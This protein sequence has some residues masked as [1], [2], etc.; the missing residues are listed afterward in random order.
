MSKLK[1]PPKKDRATLW[2]IAESTA[3]A[4]NKRD[5]IMGALFRIFWTLEDDEVEWWLA[6]TLGS[7]KPDTIKRCTM[8]RVVRAGGRSVPF[9]WPENETE[10]I[11]DLANLDY[12]DYIVDFQI[13]F[14]QPLICSRRSF[15]STVRPLA[16]PI[17]LV[18]AEADTSEAARQMA[19]TMH[20]KQND[21]YSDAVDVALT[22]WK[23]GDEM[24]HV[25]MRDFLHKKPDYKS[26]KRDR[27]KSRLAQA[28]REIGKPWLIFGTKERREHL[29][30]NPQFSNTMPQAV[31]QEWIRGRAEPPRDTDR[32]PPS[33][34]QSSGNSGCG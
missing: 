1:F 11:P 17:L 9:A 26:L 27:L 8:A 18:A 4:R 21:P 2:E 19:A 16:E 13:K 25:E 5:A 28:A 33:A 12:A 15:E 22:L 32:L 34:H 23:G 24:D 6:D 30:H 10:A 7:Q 14:I 29:N 3:T 31:E 20:T